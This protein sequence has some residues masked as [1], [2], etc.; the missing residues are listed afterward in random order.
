MRDHCLTIILT[1]WK[2]QNF[3]LDE[4]LVDIFNWNLSASQRRWSLNRRLKGQGECHKKIKLYH[5]TWIWG[6]FLSRLSL[7][8]SHK[9][10]I[11]WFSKFLVCCI[12]VEEAIP[13]SLSILI[14]YH[15]WEILSRFLLSV[16][17]CSVES[18][19]Y[20]S[21]LDSWPGCNPCLA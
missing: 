3:G 21:D 5:F 20:Q 12:R 10:C 18:I 17:A 14:D 19:I 15:V 7:A 4:Q 13:T 9:N 1:H 8:I 2:S 11:V 6:W 16:N